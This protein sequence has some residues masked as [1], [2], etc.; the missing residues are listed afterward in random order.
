MTPK[1]SYISSIEFIDNLEFDYIETY[2]LQR[3]SEF[4]QESKIGFKE[5]D[6]L[7]RRQ[8]KKGDLSEIEISRLKKLRKLYSVT[9]YLITSDGGFHDSAE[10]TGTF[11][12]NNEIIEKLKSILNTPIKEVPSWMC[13]PFYRDA[14]VFYDSDNKIVSTLNVCLSCEYMETKM[15]NHINADAE[16]Y[17]KMREFFIG[18]GHKV[19]E[20]E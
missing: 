18:L 19:E 1:Y 16:T 20:E 7:N 5:F 11:K 3:G 12:I 9:Q 4:E 8:E 6:K 17:T 13:A 14:I 2:S 15:F 10:K